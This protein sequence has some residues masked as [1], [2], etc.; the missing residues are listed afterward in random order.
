LAG[1]F[2]AEGQDE[3]VVVATSAHTGPTEIANNAE[4]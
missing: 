2:V 3:T 1:T 4:A